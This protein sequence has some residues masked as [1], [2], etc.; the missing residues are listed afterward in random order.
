MANKKSQRLIFVYMFVI[1]LTI[2][3]LSLG[4]QYLLA[5]SLFILLLLI[6]S[7]G[8]LKSV[9]I[10]L[11]LVF[12]LTL[13]YP[14]APEYLSLLPWFAIISFSLNLFFYLDKQKKPFKM[15]L[16]LWVL[17]FFALYRAVD[18]MLHFGFSVYLL[19][20]YQSSSQFILTL[21]LKPF[22]PFLLAAS[23]ANIDWQ[24]VSKG[25][26]RFLEEAVLVS[27]VLS[28]IFAVSQ[29][30]LSKS[31]II[32]SLSVYYTPPSRLVSLVKWA[33]AGYLP[34]VLGTFGNANQ[35]GVFSAITILYVLYL[36]R[37]RNLST[38]EKVALA[39]FLI[40]AVSVLLLT[41][42]R[43]SIIGLI[44]VLFLDLF[45]PP[46]KLS[47]RKVVNLILLSSVVVPLLLF[48]YRFTYVRYALEQKQ[49]TP[50]LTARV[51][52]INYLFRQFS[53]PLPS[54]V[55]F[56]KGIVYLY[57]PEISKAT[58]GA[59]DNEYARVIIAYGVIGFLIFLIVFLIIF[60]KTIHNVHNVSALGFCICSTV[61][62]MI[63]CLGG[64]HF[65]ANKPGLLFL[66]LLSLVL[67]S[68]SS[69][70]SELGERRN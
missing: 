1:L 49:Q 9:F 57:Q 14:L 41:Q 63:V 38:K 12:L 5:G 54:E 48:P 42:S 17:F 7:V 56:G 40:I 15:D 11:I 21:F 30:L 64:E 65:S 8:S 67:Y 47:K 69:R 4:E 23:I 33:E 20:A 25:Y 19:P 70:E 66:F 13:Y 28:F 60:L 44:I 50:S 61:F 31:I 35:L 45:L 36:L 32:N 62:L 37:R 59:A 29:A 53:N 16:L 68:E 10:S 24:K 43:K 46:L 22:M 55:I 52:I 27:A 51:E 34:R 58:L 3:F 6:G 39:L 18:D 2:I 26:K